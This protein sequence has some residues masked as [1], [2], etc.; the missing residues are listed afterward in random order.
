MCLYT[1]TFIDSGDSK[2]KKFYKNLLVSYERLSKKLAM[3]P[4]VCNC[5][6]TVYHGIVFMNDFYTYSHILLG[7]LDI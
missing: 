4:I 3:H 7:I 5:G 6:I 1:Q 2:E